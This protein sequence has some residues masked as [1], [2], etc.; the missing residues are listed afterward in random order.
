MR[1][2]DEQGPVVVNIPPDI[3]PEI[4]DD[5]MDRLIKAIDEAWGPEEEEQPKK[6]S[7]TDE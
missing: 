2:K 6:E 4:L 7:S 5:F 3:P 1:K